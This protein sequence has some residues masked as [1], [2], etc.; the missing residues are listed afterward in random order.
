[1]LEVRAHE[2]DAGVAPAGEDGVFEVW[3]QGH[4][5]SGQADDRRG[6]EGF[7]S[8]VGL[9]ASQPVAGGYE[10]GLGGRYFTYCF[11]CWHWA[12]TER[13]ATVCQCGSRDVK[14]QRVDPAWGKDYHSD[15]VA[16]YLG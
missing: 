11:A 15:W 8:I 2:D 3:W 7:V 6:E 9:G 1:M 13:P 12:W 14:S 16:T 5:G 10:G 4:R